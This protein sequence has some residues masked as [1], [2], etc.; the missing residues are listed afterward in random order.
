MLSTIGK[1]GEKPIELVRQVIQCPGL[2]ADA[3]AVPDSVINP[4]DLGTI[5]VPSG[6]LVLGPGQVPTLECAA[7]CRTR[8]L[9]RALLRA[10]F[11]S[12]PQRWQRSHFHSARGCAKSRSQAAAGSANCGAGFSRGRPG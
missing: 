6:W 12:A 3:I 11:K 8:K 4:V 9:P 2:E 5:L 7:I 1:S 10:G